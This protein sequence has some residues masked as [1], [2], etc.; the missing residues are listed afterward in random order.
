MSAIETDGLTKEFDE[1]TA[2]DGLDL[3]VEDG[4]IYGFLGPNGAGKST[5]INMLLDFVRPTAGSAAVLGHDPRED[6]AKIRRK[7]GIL[8]EGGQLYERLTAREHL[9]WIGQTK[10]ADVDAESLLDRVGLAS[11][12][13][14][15][16]V[17]GF[18]KGMQQRLAFGMALVG[19]PELLLL[20]EP[21]SGLDPTGMQEMREIIREEV[22]AGRTVFFSSHILGEVEAV[23]DRIGIMNQGTI[24]AEGTLD[25]LR[26]HLDAGASIRCTV[27]TVPA[28]IDFDSIPAVEG[29]TTEDSQIEVTLSD[30]RAKVDVVRQLDEQSEVL[31]ILSEDTSLEQ[32][33]NTYTANGLGGSDSTIDTGSGSTADAA[34]ESDTDSAPDPTGAKR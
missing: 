21:S 31:D 34:N 27:D 29:V 19:E 5:T 28:D 13:A 3:Q 9:R 4:E 22:D 20:D 33:F 23:C 10:N 16:P 12:D 1:I 11:E 17:G 15:R 24:V 7:T 18:S 6:A 8:P 2:V 30:P 32:L 25:E 14:D 26:D